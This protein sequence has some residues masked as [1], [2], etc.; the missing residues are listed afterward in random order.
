M[1]LERG[2]VGFAPMRIIAAPLAL[3]IALATT[4]ACKGGSAFPVLNTIEQTVAADL[5]AGKTDPQIAS[6][7]C[8]DLGG[9]TQTDAVCANAEQL[10]QTIITALIDSGA[11]SGLAL[12]NGQ[13]YMARHA[14][15]PAA[16]TS[17]P[18]PAAK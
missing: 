3:V 16:S 8:A 12:T 2:L 14:P 13:A 18:A 6:D 10:A 5:A 11:L 17:T 7:I 9:S 15:S 4:P 1:K